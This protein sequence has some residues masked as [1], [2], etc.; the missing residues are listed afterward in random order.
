MADIAGT[1]ESQ[2]LFLRQLRASCTVDVPQLKA[3]FQT[4]Q[5]AL[6][7]IRKNENM[8]SMMTKLYDMFIDI[9]EKTARLN[10][11]AVL[12]ALKEHPV[13]NMAVAEPSLVVMN[14]WSY[15]TK[16]ERQ[17]KDGEKLTAVERALA[18]TL[19]E[20]LLHGQI[21]GHEKLLK[22]GDAMVPQ[23]LAKQLESTAQKKK[24]ALAKLQ[25]AESGPSSSTMGSPTESAAAAA[26]IGATAPGWD[27][28]NSKSTGPALAPNPS[29]GKDV[30]PASSAQPPPC[31]EH[32]PAIEGTAEAMPASE[33]TTA[34]PAVAGAAAA[35]P[36]SSD[37]VEPQEPLA[38]QPD[39]LPNQQAAA[40]QPLTERVE[41]QESLAAQPGADQC[42][43]QVEARAVETP[44]SQAQ[45][46]HPAS[47]ATAESLA[48]GLRFPKALSRHEGQID[49]DASWDDPS[50]GD[51][52][53]LRQ[54]VDEAW[55][56]VCMEER[57]P[58]RVVAVDD[59]ALTATVLANGQETTVLL[60][61]GPNKL[62]VAPFDGELLCTC[63]SNAQLAH[64]LRLA[65]LKRKRSM[66]SGNPRSSVKEQEQVKEE[67][68]VAATQPSSARYI[69]MY[70]KQN[71]KRRAALAIRRKGCPG[72]NDQI[73][74]IVL[75]DGVPREVAMDVGLTVAKWLE[76][77]RFA[78][79]DVPDLLAMGVSSKMG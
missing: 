18:R 47:A 19:R 56:E 11:G 68:G 29:T 3:I 67:D 72:M 34:S 41:P 59:V 22:K 37:R 74:Q 73:G 4:H 6:V 35:Q 76:E 28:P 7:S 2:A 42:P 58:H 46:T 64:D 13:R 63:I 45:V 57:Q 55:A 12:A 10:S 8:E 60:V 39:Q 51:A 32:P 33:H 25:S 69:A 65:A 40:A 75:S 17:M 48:M 9:L 78:E 38:A 30:P 44:Q 26:S 53:H 24:E 71:S 31:M 62:A 27:L 77:K 21:L 54:M 70:Y 52:Q 66:D 50:N 20:K 61:P 5:L 49:L 36:P 43:N 15:I 1:P 16:V 14:V 79:S 23:E